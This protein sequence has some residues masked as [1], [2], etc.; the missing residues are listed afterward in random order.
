MMQKCG[1][2]NLVYENFVFFYYSINYLR[3]KSSLAQFIEFWKFPSIER[4]LLEATFQKL[5]IKVDE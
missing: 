2:M 5:P 1:Q 3:N 4:I